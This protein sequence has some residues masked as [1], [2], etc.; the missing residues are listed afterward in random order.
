[1]YGA[2]EYLFGF[3]IEPYHFAI[4]VAEAVPVRLREIVEFVYV[5]IDGAR[6]ELV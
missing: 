6:C 5:E 3:A 4:A 1:V 2:N